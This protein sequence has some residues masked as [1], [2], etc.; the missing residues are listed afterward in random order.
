[1]PRITKTVTTEHGYGCDH[2]GKVISDGEHDGLGDVNWWGMEIALQDAPQEKLEIIAYRH[3]TERV[4]VK[5]RNVGLTGQREPPGPRWLVCRECGGVIHAAIAQ[6]IAAGQA[7]S[8]GSQPND[9]TPGEW[10]G[11]GHG[12][13]GLAIDRELRHGT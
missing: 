9:L 4:E 7:T 2:C 3:W 6:A 12:M 10:M 1:M 5:V 8:G 13:G 11:E